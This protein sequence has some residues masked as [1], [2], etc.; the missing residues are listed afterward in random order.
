MVQ[1][2]RSGESTITKNIPSETF[3]NFMKQNPPRTS[4]FPD[5]SEK[6]KALVYHP[7][8]V[9]ETIH[10]LNESIVTLEDKINRYPSQTTVLQ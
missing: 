8:S 1:L 5:F 3:L 4:V 6:Y 10:N 2:S 9:H 7:D